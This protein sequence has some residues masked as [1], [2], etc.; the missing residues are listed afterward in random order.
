MIRS[1]EIL[2]PAAWAGTH[3]LRITTDAEDR[4]FE[5]GDPANNTAISPGP[6]QILAPDLVPVSLTVADAQAG[7]PFPV[8]WSV[9]NAGN[10]DAAGVWLDRLTLVGPAGER[11]LGTYPRPGTAPLG[12]LLTQ[13]Q[14]LQIIVPLT[15]DFTPGD[16]RLRLDTDSRADLLESSKTNNRI[17][18][19]LF[20]IGLPPLPDLTLHRI[21][22]PIGSAPGGVLPVTWELAN[23]GAATVPAGSILRLDLVP[24]PPAIPRTLLTLRIDEPIPAGSSLVRT[25]NVIIPT[26]SAG[27]IRI[28]AL[29]DATGEV[30]ESDETNNQLATALPTEV[31]RQITWSLPVEV[32]AENAEPPTVRA[33]LTRSG[34][35]DSL[36][37][38]A[39][40]SADT[41]EVVLPPSVSFPIGTAT[42]ELDVQVMADGLVDGPKPTLLTADAAGF[43]PGYFTLTVLDADRARLT[44]VPE[45]NRVVEGLS[46]PVIIRR[47][48]PTVDPLQI[49]LS[50]STGDLAPPATVSLPA[51]ASEVAF[52]LI[53]T[54]ND[55]LESPRPITLTAD[56][57]GHLSS[58]VEI[59]VLDNDDPGLV[60]AIAPTQIG[61]GDGPLAATAT[62]TRSQ[63]IG[64]LLRVRI[65]ASDDG[66]LVVPPEVIFAPGQTTVRFHAGPVDDRINNGPAEVLVTAS[67]MAPVTGGILATSA[68]VNVRVEDDDGASLRLSLGTTVAREGRSPAFT[69][70][71]LR[72]SPV[73]QPLTVQLTVSDPTEASVPESVVIP[74]GQTSV[75]FPVTTLEDG[76]IDGN[77][78]VTL[79]ATAIQHAPAT[80]LFTVTDGN[81]PDLAFAQVTVS[82]SGI[83]GGEGVI[84]WRLINQGFAP[85]R[86]PFTQRLHFSRDNLLDAADVLIEETVFSGTLQPGESI[87]RNL[88]RRLPSETG[89]W[90]VIAVADA[91]GAVEEVLESNNL[92]FAGNLLRVDP[93]Y[94]ATV[95]TPIDVAPAGTPIPLT[96]RALKPDGTPAP[97]E[98]VRIQV[99]VRETERSLS[100]LTDAEGRFETVFQP[101]AGEFGVYTLSA[102]HPG[103]PAPAAQDQF[104]LIGLRL[105]PVY[106]FTRVVPGRTNLLLVQLTNPNARSMT[107]LQ[108]N[109]GAVDDLGVAVEGPLELAPGESGSAVIRVWSRADRD[110]VGRFT[111]RMTSGEGARMDAV[112]DYTVELPQPRLVAR[113]TRLDSGVV[114]GSQATVEFEVINQGGADSG[115]LDVTLPDLPWMRVASALPLSSLAPGESVQVTLALTPD[116][117]LALGLHEGRL[118]VGNDTGR[119]TVP[120]S[121]RHVSEALGDVRVPVHDENTYYGNGSLVAGAAVVLRDVYDN[122]PVTSATTDTHGVVLFTDVPEG[123]YNLEVTAPRHDNFLRT[124]QVGPGRV[125]ETVAFLRTQLVRYNW[126]V[127]EVDFEE[128]ARIQLDTI[129]ETT[130]PV[131]VVTIE[132]ALIDLTGITT[133]T[134]T[135]ELKVSNQGLIAVQDVDLRFEDGSTWRVNPL[136]TDL[137]AIPPKSSISVPVTFTRITNPAAPGRNAAPAAGP[138]DTGC[139]P[140]SVGVGWDLLCGPFGVAY[141]S[142]VFVVDLGLCPPP[143]SGDPGRSQGQLYIP[144]FP[145]VPSPGKGST[146]P[147]NIG[148]GPSG[149]TSFAGTNDCN[150]LK[151]GYIKK[152]VSAEAGYKADASAAAQSVLNAVLGPVKWLSVQGF[153]V[154]FGGAAKLCTC[155][156]EVNGQGV[157]GLQA[158]AELGG[159]IEVKLFAGPQ[160]QVDV[161][162]VSFP[163]L[164]GASAELFVGAGV[165]LTGTGSVKIQASTECFLAKPKVFVDARIRIGT[166][167]GLKG[168]GKI[169]GTLADGTAVELSAEAFGGVDLGAYAYFS[170]YLVGG[171]GSEPTRDG[172]IEPIVL[173]AELKVSAGS[174]PN[175]IGGGASITQEQSK[176]ICL[177]EAT[178]DSLPRFTP[179]TEA[180]AVSRMLGFS[181]PAELAVGVTHQP[182]A[183]DSLAAQPTPRELSD[184]LVRHLGLPTRIAASTAP[185]PVFSQT[186][187]A[188]PVA[189]AAAQQAANAARQGRHARPAAA[190]DGVCAQVKLVI[191]QQAVVTRKGIGATLEIINESTDT[192]LEDI[193]VAIQIQDRFGNPANDRFII[194][195]PELTRLQPMGQPPTNQLILGGLALTLPADS[196]GSARWLIVPRDSAAPDEPVDYFVGGHLAYRSGDITRTAELIPGTVTVHPNARLFL[197][198]FHQRDVFADDPFTDVIEPSEPFVLGVMVENRGRG[199]ARNFS[200]T[201]AQPRIVDNAKGLLVHFD[202]LAAHVAGRP[203]SPSLTVGFGDVGPGAISIGRWL[204]QSSIQGL[205]LDYSATLEHEDR[206]G[207]RGASVFEGVEIHELIRQVDAD[208]SFADGQPD[209]LVNDVAD[210]DD[211]P[212]TLHLSDGS[213]RPVAVVREAIAEGTPVADNLEVGI[214]AVTPPGWVYL[215]IPDPAQGRF[216]LKEVRR[217]DGSILHAP[218]NAWVTDRTFIGQGRRPLL[219]HTVHLLDHDSPGRYTLVYQH[220]DSLPDTVPPSS[221]VAALSETSPALIPVRW[222]GSDDDQGSGIDSFDV[223][224]SIDGGSFQRWLDGVRTVSAFYPGAAGRRYAFYS[225][226]RDVAGNVEAVPGTPDTSTVATGNSAPVLASVADVTVDEGARIDLTLRATDLDLPGDT[227]RF[228]LVS[229]P[230]GAV[231]DPVTGRFT[232]QT[233]EADGPST[234]IVR[235]QVEDDGEPPLTSGRDFRVT[236]R[237][238]NLPVTIDPVAPLF[239][240]EEGTLFRLMLTA[241]DPDLPANPLRYRLLTGAPAGATLNPVSGEL[242]W[243]PTESQGG[244]SHGF[245]VEV[246]DQGNPP[247]TS[248]TAFTV[249]V[250]KVNGVPTLQPIADRTVWE[251]DRVEIQV[252]AS[253]ADLPVQTLVFSLEQGGDLGAALNPQSGLFTWIPEEQHANATNRFTVAVTD[254]GEPALGAQ[255]SFA[256]RVQPLHPGLNL[257]DR[258]T[259]GTVSFRYKGRPGVRAALQASIDLRD[260]TELSEFVPDAPVEHLVERSSTDFPWRYFRVIEK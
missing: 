7:Q 223:F 61:E 22:A 65:S 137:G 257:P 124:I 161:P 175:S 39:L 97:A 20:R 10:A 217:P 260:W 3:T 162:E 84:S 224:V 195:P 44:L 53:A 87:E 170:G 89:E 81:L 145:H 101:V 37:E 211:L 237:E 192:P 254:S 102:S 222:S 103:A 78:P 241:T 208:R 75:T 27:P 255:R 85:A 47:S 125:N 234:R 79:S 181:S 42:V 147:I 62:L 116:E 139:S 249:S 180:E 200:I 126:R 157:V 220:D 36:L 112:I 190:T 221:Q 28:R 122:S 94:T 258:A 168:T 210:P 186:Y 109:A 128:R 5:T 232:W 135:I 202:I 98:W 48:E 141:W 150:C 146:F 9:R 68:P 252:Q 204:L 57:E 69:A 56:A 133:D 74:A 43:N 167:I 11:L 4:V 177:I 165:E 253:D 99:R 159:T 21:T 228:H 71:V 77:Q 191:E 166:P 33:R 80:A 30:V 14:A 38:V 119:V 45:T 114:R 160:F 59:T 130:V 58:A 92:A 174:G 154:K 214:T 242:R 26:S 158:E 225:V 70:V 183:A 149:F 163:G 132:P 198:Y 25:S 236:I 151:D 118:A 66:R 91:S 40:T 184:T 129:F 171:D 155:C 206:F 19:A 176:K 245:E 239:Q 153:E 8:E 2:F 60:L 117:T 244:S 156:E 93:A 49:N 46:I 90:R 219:E 111:V 216:A 16:Y 238:V 231:L 136:A 107:G 227:L 259:D 173:R 215:R 52:A 196:T 240:V 120:F 189:D 67:V 23:T 17:E 193:G 197:K 256:L 230:A 105:D 182:D 178:P 185:V 235:V 76:Q 199:I 213:T 55:R 201:S 218:T 73:T 148:F 15:P 54:E 121:I 152:C 18:S 134:H 82:A 138:N 104:E 169:T 123:T 131:P 1:R 24:E 63:G 50:S 41:N 251:G 194:L 72:N 243:I 110:A 142:P 172:C 106:Q 226:A 83:T 143:P 108:F 13:T 246:T 187:T 144:Q 32:I 29:A 209:F 233:G 115:P 203:V 140:P 95:S 34:P 88:T 179:L 229:G 188:A 127:E 12:S 51:G 248:R 205:F 31:S 6:F 250:A 86:G 212:D 96:G 164:T 35:L 207:E 64:R 113:P 247:T 100:A